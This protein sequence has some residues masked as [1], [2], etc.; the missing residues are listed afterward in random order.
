MDY[1]WTLL[2]KQSYVSIPSDVMAI[3]KQW[4]QEQNKLKE[5]IGEDWIDGD[6]VFSRKNGKPINPT[7]I[8]I[9]LNRFAEK[10]NLPHIHAHKFRHSQASILINQG[11]D[12]VTVSKRLGHSNT[13]TTGDIYAHILKKAD[14]KASSVLTGVLKF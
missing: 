1:K 8:G 9:Y 6:Y 14:E 7:S 11:M 4:K 3:L 12:I 13:S 5:A 2:K 10:Y